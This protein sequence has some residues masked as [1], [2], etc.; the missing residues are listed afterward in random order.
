MLTDY[1][2]MLFVTD[3]FIDLIMSYFMTTIFNETENLRIL[4]NVT[5]W[6]IKRELQIEIIR[7]NEKLHRKKNH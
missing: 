3:R 5:A 4:K 6:I 7:S 1:I 2:K